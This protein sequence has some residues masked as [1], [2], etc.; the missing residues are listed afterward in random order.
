MTPVNPSAPAFAR[1]T[2][3]GDYGRSDGGSNGM[4]TRTY[5]AGLAM[6]G[7]LGNRG[8]LDSFSGQGDI[9]AFAVELADHLIAALNKPTS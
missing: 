3:Y 1:A 2:A 4:S 5:L 6:Q 7:L 9:A 8:I